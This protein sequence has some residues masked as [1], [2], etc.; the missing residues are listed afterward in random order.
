M[1]EQLDRIESLLTSLSGQLQSVAV[2][3]GGNAEA[4]GGLKQDVV[5]LR[6]ELKQDVVE[7][8]QELKQDVV[9]LRQELKQDVVELRQE[10]KQDISDLKAD[11]SRV[12]ERLDGI[13]RQLNGEV[14]QITQM[15]LNLGDQMERYEQAIEDF[16]RE[17]R[18]IVVEMQHMKG[19]FEAHMR[20][21]DRIMDYLVRHVGPG[22]VA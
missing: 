7:L 16:K 20:R 10:L 18:T 1:S 13:E 5:E 17:V 9:E 12:D 14:T 21:T 11:V 3:V 6:Q 8:R 4:I 2:Q 19:T 22:D 15:V